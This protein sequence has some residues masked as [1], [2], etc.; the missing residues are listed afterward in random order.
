MLS[1]D[2]AEILVQRLEI[3]EKELTKQLI[4]SGAD[5]HDFIRGQ[6]PAVATV[7]DEVVKII[8]EEILNEEVL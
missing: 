8:K 2:F 7:R 6:I 1:T 3:D 5:R 4:K